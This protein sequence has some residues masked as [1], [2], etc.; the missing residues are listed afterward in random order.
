[1]TMNKLLLGLLGMVALSAVP[2]W[3][4]RADVGPSSS[5]AYSPNNSFSGCTAPSASDPILNVNGAPCIVILADPSLD[6][7]GFNAFQLFVGS[8]TAAAG[9]V[10]EIANFSNDES[11]TFSFG[12]N[13]TDPGSP[14]FGSLEAGGIPYIYPTSVFQDMVND[15]PNGNS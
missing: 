4:S 12:F 5:G 6:L 10:Y 3:A 15:N 2:A 11:V 9:E 8:S 1:M 13:P 7:D 14:T